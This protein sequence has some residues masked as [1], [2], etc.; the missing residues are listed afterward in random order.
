MTEPT[1]PPLPERPA[2]EVSRDTASGAG[3]AGVDD[4][5]VPRLVGDLDDIDRAFRWAGQLPIGQAD[6]YAILAAPSPLE[7]IE[8]LSEAVESVTAAIRF[9]LMD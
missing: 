4:T 7:R 5:G 6:R 9:Q 3:I 1:L 8:A 2:E